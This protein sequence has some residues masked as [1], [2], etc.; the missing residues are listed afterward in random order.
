ML[1]KLTIEIDKEHNLWRIT[2]HA[3]GLVADGHFEGESVIKTGGNL[4]D[5]C[6]LHLLKAVLDGEICRIEDQKL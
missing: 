6:V 1:V 4:N 3:H 5:E 2:D